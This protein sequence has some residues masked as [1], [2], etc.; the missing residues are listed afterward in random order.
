MKPPT[1]ASTCSGMPR[2]CAMAPIAS[3]GSML[4]CGYSGAE[5]S[6]ITVW[7][8][9]SRSSLATSACS[10]LVQRQQAQLHAEV[11]A[12]LNQATCA[13]AG[14]TISGLRTPRLARARSR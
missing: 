5:P 3:I 1:Q 6:T 13:V 10:L 14:T 12:A 8:L 11:L 2:R 4:P 7:R 9:I